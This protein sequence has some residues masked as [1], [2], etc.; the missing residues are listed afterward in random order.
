M[1]ITTDMGNIT[2]DNAVWL[3]AQGV[4]TRHEGEV[5]I[6]DNLVHHPMLDRPVQAYS[7]FLWCYDDVAE[8]TGLHQKD[9]VITAM[10]TGAVKG[11]DYEMDKVYSII[12]KGVE[13]ITQKKR[14]SGSGAR[15]S[16][17]F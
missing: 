14:E 16:K 12:E 7:L 1:L 13:L 15:K 11:R 2:K 3:N 6:A 5:V 8:Q 17:S 10:R 9:D 4:I